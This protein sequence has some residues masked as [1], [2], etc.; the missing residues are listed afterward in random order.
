MVIEDDKA[1]AALRGDRRVLAELTAALVRPERHNL[2]ERPWG[3]NWIRRFKRVP[4]DAAGG[5]SP[6]G[7]AFEISAFSEDFEAARF[8]S[9]LRFDDGS[10]LDLPDLLESQGEALLGEPFVRRY[11]AR[12]PL[13]PKTLSIKELLSVQGH[14]AGHTEVYVI[15]DAEPGATLRLGFE[16]D[17]DAVELTRSLTHGIAL[18]A[19]LLD[20]LGPDVDAAELQTLVAPWFA[21]RGAERTVLATRLEQHPAVSAIEP[22]VWPLLDEL[23]A[24]YWMVLDSMN[25]IEVQPG[26]VIYNATPSRLLAG[27]GAAASAEVHALGNPEGREILALE[28]RRPGA[29]FRAWDNVRFPTRD[30]DVAAAVEALNLRATRPEEFICDPAPIPGREGA[31]LSVD[32]EHFR[33]EHLR[34]RRGRPVEVPVSHPHSL[35]CLAGCVELSTQDGRPIGRLEMGESALVPVGVGA[36]RVEAAVPAATAEA[37]QAPDVVR[38]VLPDL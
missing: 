16:R 7:E 14:P 25:A 12:F 23:K 10:L 32:C 22:A 26:Q 11:G 4:A 24:L 20:M 15:I 8:P 27:T 6:W 28:I 31:F 29:T 13:L 38:A 1:R 35:H 30:V 19:R 9:R 37:E 2:V 5:A 17:L 33:V 34:P 18:Q 21:D 36:Y 3:G